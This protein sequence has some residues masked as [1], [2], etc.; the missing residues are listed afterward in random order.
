MHSPDTMDL[1]KPVH[2]DSLQQ[3]AFLN[4]W[5]SYDRLKILEDDLFCQH[6]LTAQQYNALRLLKAHSPEKVPTL[7]LAAQL[8]SRAPDITRLLDRLYARGFIDRERKEANRRTVY[9]GIT[10]KGLELLTT[11]TKQVRE[12]HL[13]QLGHLSPEELKQFTDLLRKARLPHEPTDSTWR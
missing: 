8:V 9:V 10:E 7:Q 1:E 11:L 5:R 13:R 6:D 12:C 2:F 3:E 4:L